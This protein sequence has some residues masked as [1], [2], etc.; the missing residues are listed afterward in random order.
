[1]RHQHLFAVFS[2]GVDYLRLAQ[3]FLGR[4]AA[5]DAGRIQKLS[6]ILEIPWLP[7]DEFGPFVP[8]CLKPKTHNFAFSFA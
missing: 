2:P 8:D 7:E 1:M 5:D 6:E 4:M 3:S